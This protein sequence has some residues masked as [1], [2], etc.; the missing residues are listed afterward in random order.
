MTFGSGDLNH[1]FVPFR[2][3]S[4]QGLFDCLGPTDAS[5]GSGNPSFNDCQV[6]LSTNNATSTSDQVFFAIQVPSAT[7]KLNC[8]I[9]GS[10]T[11]TKP[12]TNVIALMPHGDPK[13]VKATKIKGAG[14]LGTAAGTACG[15]SHQPALST[16]Y[17]VVS[18]SAKFKG[19]FPAGS[20]CSALSN[21]KFAGTTVKLK[22]QG[23]NPNSGNL[24]TAGKSDVTLSNGTV[25]ALPTGG[26]VASGQ[27]TAGSFLG[28]TVRVQL[29]LNGGVTGETTLCN[30]G[31]LAGVD[32]TGA[33]RPS[34]IAIL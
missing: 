33:L 12:L 32:F 30:G 13:P 15:N 28:S 7:T 34:S 8:R 6:R 17:P 14:T 24:S 4:P 1:R 22:W 18:G 20:N 11:F 21:P 2:G 23:I 25:A 19:S 16:K 3:T 5:T 10:L 31:S 9:S 27:I 26:F 29:A